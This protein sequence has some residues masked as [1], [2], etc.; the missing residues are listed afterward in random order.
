MQAGV[1]LAWMAAVSRAEKEWL[2]EGESE[3]VILVIVRLGRRRFA[4]QR[5]AGGTISEDRSA[6]LGGSIVGVRL[7][8]QWAGKQPAE[9]AS[10]LAREQA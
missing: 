6:G 7:A 8:G 4:F 3:L 9:R 5:D 10:R 2:D 1:P